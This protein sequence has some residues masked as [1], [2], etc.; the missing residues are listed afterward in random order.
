MELMYSDPV[1][2]YSNLVL[3]SVLYYYHSPDCFTED[4]TI[5]KNESNQV[6][7]NPKPIYSAVDSKFN[8]AYSQEIVS[9]IAALICGTISS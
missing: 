7:C 4:T 9:W 8:G 3:L 5:T 6:V 2:F 1:M